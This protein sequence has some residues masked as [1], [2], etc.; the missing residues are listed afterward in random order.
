MRENIDCIK[1]LENFL[2]NSNP[3]KRKLLNYWI[4]D[5]IKFLKFEDEFKT[6]S[7][8]KYKRGEIIKAHLGFN[9]GA[10][11]GGLHY[12]VVLDNNNSQNSPTITVA[13]LT[14]L[15]D[16]KDLNNLYPTELYIGTKLFDLLHLKINTILEENKNILKFFKEMESHN[17]IDSKKLLQVA[18]KVNECRR[19]LKEISKLKS[20]SIILLNQITTISKIRI[21]DPKRND[22]SLAKIKLPNDVMDEIDNKIANFYL[23]KSK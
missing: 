16:N 22:D 21:Y 6:S 12:C 20:G 10:E 17:K 19:T 9:I 8:R 4:K 5:Y 11:F 2:K 7:L 1:E 15:K 14:S 18:K 3:K 13:P 23:K